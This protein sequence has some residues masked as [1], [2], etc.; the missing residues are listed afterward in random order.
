MQNSFSLPHLLKSLLCPLP[1]DLS[2][3]SRIGTILNIIHWVFERSHFWQTRTVQFNISSKIYPSC[4]CGG[5]CGPN[6]CT[7]QKCILDRV[8]RASGYP[9]KILGYNVGHRLYLYI[10]RLSIGLVVH[11]G[12]QFRKSDKKSRILRTWRGRQGDWAGHFA[13]VENILRLTLWETMLVN[14]LLSDMLDL[15]MLPR[16]R[17]DQRFKYPQISTI[18]LPVEIKSNKVRRGRRNQRWPPNIYLFR[19]SE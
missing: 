3:Y 6:V 1:F 11:I 18:S 14:V 15:T 12:R 17:D 16:S 5:N 9:R 13:E 7:K 8:R 10:L 4:E 2:T 19:H